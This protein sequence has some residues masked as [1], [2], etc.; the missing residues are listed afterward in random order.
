MV[1]R[2]LKADAGPLMPAATAGGQ[3]ELEAALLLASNRAMRRMRMK[4]RDAVGTPFVNRVRL[5]T[6]ELS[7][8]VA[9]HA[10]DDFLAESL[11]MVIGD[12]VVGIPGLRP[13]PGRDHLDLHLIGLDGD[14]QGEVR[15]LGVNRA[16]WRETLQFMDSMGKVDLRLWSEC[17]GEL[18]DGE[19]SLLWERS[20]Q[21]T[22]LMSAVL[23]RF[24][25]WRDAAWLDSAIIG[26]SL[27]MR[28]QAGPGER[29][30]AS[31]LTDS[32]CGVPGA[33][34]ASCHV[35]STIRSILLSRTELISTTREDLAAWARDQLDGGQGKAFRSVQALR[36]PGTN[37]GPPVHSDIWEI[38]DMRDALARRDMP[39]LYRM[40]RRVGV[41]QRQLATLTGQPIQDVSATLKGRQVLACDTLTQIADGLGIPRPY[42]G[43]AHRELPDRRNEFASRSE[44]EAA[45]R[46]F[47]MHAAAVTVGTAVLGVGD[48]LGG[49]WRNRSQ[50]FVD[51]ALT[52]SE[53]ED[54]ERVLHELRRKCGRD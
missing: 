3:L 54:A 15:L 28:W 14:T 20:T 32:V 48:S 6:R 43:L 2:Q 42:L 34:L 5:A 23:R 8:E 7:L 47:L 18:H 26:D 50:R 33:A 25:L 40:L 21:P 46:R 37:P 44:E 9:E 17:Q 11:P 22:E 53:R 16:R 36:S 19:S 12:R 41:S 49:N 4:E 27:R 52:D 45:R 1:R 31:I 30:I 13:R 39:A 29:A 38:L 51:D 35:S 10:V 24:P